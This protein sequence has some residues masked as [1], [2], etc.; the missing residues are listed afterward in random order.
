MTEQ[1]TAAEFP[2]DEAIVRQFYRL[3]DRR[4]ALYAK[5]QPFEDR[6]TAVN[7]EIMA[8]QEEASQLAAEID[9]GL[10]GESFLQLKREIRRIASFLRFIPPRP[11]G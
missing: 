3:S 1:I 6:L 7:A 5:V 9:R 8:R 2:A 4:D 11:E 10:G